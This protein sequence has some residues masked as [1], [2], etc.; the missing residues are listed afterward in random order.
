MKAKLDTALISRMTGGLWSEE[1]A[2]STPEAK[3]EPIKEKSASLSFLQ[4]TEQGQEQSNIS[5]PVPVAEL[6]KFLKG[7]YNEIHPITG[8]PQTVEGY[9]RELIEES[10]DDLRRGNYF[11]KR[12]ATDFLR[13]L[14]SYLITWREMQRRKDL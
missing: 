2:E 10:R 3:A 5:D 11:D 9:L 12:G 7:G 8:K 4:G 13:E 6:K 1:K 14:E